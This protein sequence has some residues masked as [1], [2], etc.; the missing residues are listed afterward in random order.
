MKTYTLL[1]SLL[2]IPICVSGQTPQ[3]IKM[4]NNKIS[5]EAIKPEL[6]YI[7]P[8]FQNGKVIMKNSNEIKCKLNYSFL[9]DEVLFINENGEKMALA[10]PEEISEVH[11][12]NRL[13]IPGLKGYCEVIER[14]A[15][16]L[17]YKWTCNIAE[18]GKEGALGIPT[19]AP[20][21]VQMNRMSFDA[22][23][24]KLDVDKEAVVSV[25]VIPYLKIRSKYISVK[26][27]KDFFKATPGKKDEIKTYIS[28]NPVDF[29]KEADLRR[30]TQYCNSL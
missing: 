3:S 17:V 8:D 15:V 2:I 4:N 26:G 14:G 12:A 5:T 23:E 10:N 9:L 6:Q 18:K 24:W 28:Q 7:F 22:R 20:S 25:E 13:F 16:L 29:K 21:V 11:I 27:A 19:D 1:I 30:L